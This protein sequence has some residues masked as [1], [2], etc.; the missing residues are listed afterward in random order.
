MEAI[1]AVVVVVVAVVGNA[2]V[3][4]FN[5][6]S[7]VVSSLVAVSSDEAFSA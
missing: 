5:S 7:V 6:P 1:L 2:V 3:I 4:S